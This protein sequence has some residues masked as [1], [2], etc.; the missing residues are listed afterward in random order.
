MRY[1]GQG[2]NLSVSFPLRTVDASF[3][4]E[5]EAAFHNSY[6]KN[7]GGVLP[8]GNLE[9]VT[10]R[11]VGATREDIKRFA[12]PV[13]I[14]NLTVTPKA[15]RPIFCTQTNCMKEVV[16]Y[17]RYRLPAGTRLRGPLV[18]EESES[19]IVVPVEAEVEVLGDLS[20]LVQLGDR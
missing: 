19:T 4:V 16:V 5:L 12:W 15:R 20:V 1:V 10:W 14:A 18:L 6:E 2:A 11:I 8:S 17:D 7:Y 9:I 3:S 13:T